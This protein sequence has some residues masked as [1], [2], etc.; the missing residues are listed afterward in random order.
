VTPDLSSTA[1]ALLGLLHRS[2][3]GGP[4]APGGFEDECADLRANHLA[5]R[6]AQGVMQITADGETALRGRFELD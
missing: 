4:D 6:N 3:H 2:S 5:M 1:W